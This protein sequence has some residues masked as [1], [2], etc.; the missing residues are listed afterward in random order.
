MQ[1]YLDLLPGCMLEGRWHSSILGAQCA[2]L[3]CRARLAT[4]CRRWHIISTESHA[5]VVWQRLCVSKTPR[6]LALTFRSLM[7]W[8]QAHARHIRD[9][10]LCI[11]DGYQDV[12]CPEHACSSYFSYCLP[13]CPNKLQGGIRQRTDCMHSVLH[14]GQAEWRQP[15]HRA[16]RHPARQLKPLAAARHF[17]S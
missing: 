5:A 11:S 9:L 13:Y 3:H 4:V 7:R 1:I 6:G 8:S 16:M 10:Q 14:A 17:S 15:S 12:G 2:Y